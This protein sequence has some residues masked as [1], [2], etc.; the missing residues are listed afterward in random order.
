MRAG[1]THRFERRAMA[2]RGIGPR[3]RRARRGFTLVEALLASTVLAI[4]AVTAALPFTAGV[5]HAQEAGSL[6]RAVE[7]GEA[8]MEEVLARPFVA[9]DEGST[10]PG[11]DGDDTSR[12]KYDNV[13]DFHGFSEPAGDLGNY[14]GEPLDSETVRDFRREVSVE[15]VRFPGQAADDVDSLAHVQVRV[16]YKSALLA[17]LDRIVSRED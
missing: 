12:D 15:Y 4:V 17:R 9:A 16:Y 13:D 8:L 3:S 11:P 7:L 14:A 5:Q 1:I 2:A 6:E 10:S